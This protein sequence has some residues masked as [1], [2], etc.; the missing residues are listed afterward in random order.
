MPSQAILFS[1][2]LTLSEL[3]EPIR[4]TQIGQAHFAGTGPDGRTCRECRHF[5]CRSKDGKEYFRYQAAANAPKGPDRDVYLQA[6]HCNCP[7][8]N[9][10]YRPIDPTQEACRHFSERSEPIAMVQKDH[11]YKAN[12]SK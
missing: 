9:K 5:F 11:R 8:P 6:A 10:A 7:I 2:H 4:K 3:L 12:R 1:P